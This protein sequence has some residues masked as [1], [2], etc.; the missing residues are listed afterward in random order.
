MCGEGDVERE[1]KSMGNP[2]KKC[3]VAENGQAHPARDPE[4][5][6]GRADWILDSPMRGA[7]EARMF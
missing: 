2:L 4:P 1:E 3:S 7:E 5:G 6:Q